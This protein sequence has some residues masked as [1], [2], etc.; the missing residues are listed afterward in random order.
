[1]E[2]WVHSHAGRLDRAAAAQDAALALYPSTAYQGPA[3]VE[4]HRAICMVVAGDPSEGARH[5]VR[6]VQ[7]LPQDRRHD[8]LVRRS[9][10]L[11]FEKVPERARSL[12]AVAEARDLVGLPAGPV[13]T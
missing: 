4:L 8:G 7:A 13:V 12:P 6:I 5:T 11:V 1:M 3:L 2:S 9:A 10:T